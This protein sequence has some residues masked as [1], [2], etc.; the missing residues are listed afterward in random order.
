MPSKDSKAAE[1]PEA[2]R[3]Q[4]GENVINSLKPGETVALKNDHW[5]VF[6]TNGKIDNHRSEIPDSLYREF[7]ARP[8]IE[9][10]IEA[11]FY[12]LNVEF[13]Q[14]KT[15]HENL[16]DENVALK[17]EQAELKNELPRL[18]GFKK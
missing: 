9:V 11:K 6:L 5:C 2:A 18:R 13:A 16:L 1:V 3:E 7:L 17:L 10:D 14:L 8:E 4:L 15:Q 12:E